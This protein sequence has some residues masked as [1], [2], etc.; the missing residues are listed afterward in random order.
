MSKL[1]ERS[2]VIRRVARLAFG[3]PND[4]VKLAILD[5][6]SAD[7]GRLDLCQ[8]AEF[9]RGSN[10]VI[11]VKLADRLKALELLARLVGDSD[12]RGSDAESFFQ[13]MDDAAMR[14]SDAGT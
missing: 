8:L 7:I 1:P 6:D 4:A 2:D 11:E 13:A 9:K 10:G 5:P 12:E 14:V 3:K